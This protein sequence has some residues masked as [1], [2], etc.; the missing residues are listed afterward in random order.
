M[1]N[2][3]IIGAGNIGSRH[4][5]GLKKVN[6]P[7]SITV[8]DP[9]P[10]S[11]EIAKARYNQ[12]ES[13]TKHQ[14]TFV[15][16]IN[17]L[18]KKI[19]LAII[20]TSADVRRAVTERLLSKSE[21]K[22]LIL[23]KILFQKKKDYSDVEK[24]LNKKGVKTWVNF[25][26]RT[27]PFYRDLKE[28]FKDSIQMIVS[29]SEYGLITNSIHFLDYIAY[30]TNCYDFKVE[31]SGL[32]PKPVASKR[33][34]FLELN[35]TLNVYFKDGSFGL[36]TCYP[37]GDIPFIIQ[38]ISPN[39]RCISREAERKAY[40]SSIQ[41]RWQWKETDTNIPFQS[42]MTNAI[43]EDIL[44]TGRSSLTPYDKAFRLHLTLLESLVSFL[45]RN[46]RKKFSFYPFT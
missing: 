34:G 24:L 17:L 5:Q 28:K 37:S 15:Q 3:C 27:M 2:I 14:I 12:I 1:K 31:T 7:L 18:S 10:K 35:G 22:Y 21:V 6:F 20:A 40:I 36:F 46:G 38:V 42:D 16:N 32:D 9:S 19:D 8:S 30:L 11:L 25:S 44:K 41:D 29:G 23:E 39:Y 4:I 43:V 13:S 26:M 45:N 33:K